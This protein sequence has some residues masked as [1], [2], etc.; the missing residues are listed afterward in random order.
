MTEEARN[1]APKS[2]ARVLVAGSKGNMRLFHGKCRAH[3]AGA[4]VVTLQLII[5][6]LFLQRFFVQGLATSGMKRSS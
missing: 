4:G 3:A 1:I 5:L 2:S 6:F